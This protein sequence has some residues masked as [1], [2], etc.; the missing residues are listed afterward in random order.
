VIY[1][2]DTNAI[3]DLMW[4]NPAIESRIRNAPSNSSMAISPITRGEILY[5]IHRLSPGKKQTD[6]FALANQLFSV[7]H[8]DPLPLKA[9]DHY[10][11]IKHA[12]KSQGLSVNEND[13]WIAATAISLQA[14][15]ITRDRDFSRIMGLNLED[16]S[17]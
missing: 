10:A 3:S 14:T 15:L 9:A 13:L 12:G 2:F 4:R 5:G 11:I 8:C 16:W 17:I 6:L 7:F 1:L